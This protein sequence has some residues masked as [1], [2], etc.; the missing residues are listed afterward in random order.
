MDTAVGSM[1]APFRTINRAAQ[2]ARS[3]DTVRV[4]GGTYREWVNPR[5]GGTS[6]HNRITYEAVEG[7]HPIIKGSE[8]VTGWERVQGTV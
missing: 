3:G 5:F 6:E 1:E 8:I 4:F 7:E 2:V